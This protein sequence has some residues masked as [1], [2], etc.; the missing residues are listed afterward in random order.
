MNA[1]KKFIVLLVLSVVLVTMSLYP[2]SAQSSSGDNGKKNINLVIVLDRTRSLLQSDPNRLSQEAAKLIV[3]LMPQN[4]GKIGLVQ[5]TDKVTDRLDITAINGQEE[6]NKLKAYLDGIGVPNG[7]STDIST[8][9]KEGVGMLAGLQTL[10]HPV[11]ILLTDGKNDLNG[12]DRTFDISQRDMEQSLNTAKKKGIIVYTIGL[13]ADGSVD[14]DML[15]HIAKET[16]GKSYIVDGANLLPD[17]IDIYTNVLD[18]QLLSFGSDQISL[19]GNFDTYNFDVTNSSVADANLVIYKNGDVQARLIKPDGTEVSW[20][21]DKFIASSSRSYMSYKILNPKQGQ[22]RLMVKG[23]QNEAVKISL[24]YNYDL[25]IHMDQ[26]LSSS[27]FAGAEIPVKA[28]FMRQDTAI[29]DKNL[30][31]DMSAVAVV[32]NISAKTSEKVPLTAGEKDYHGKI[33]FEQPGNYSVYVLA[34][35]KALTSKSDPQTI[36][37][38]EKDTPV[39]AT[40]K[41][42]FPGEKFLYTLLGILTATVLVI[43]LLKGIPKFL[44]NAKPKLLFGK[45]NLKVINTKTGREEVRQSKILAPYGTSVTLSKLAENSTGLLNKIVLARNA[46]GVWLTNSEASCEDLAV[47]V[48]GDKVAPGQKVLLT[49]GSTLRVVAGEVSIKVEGRFSEF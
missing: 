34:E 41:R 17:I 13:N 45:I 11:I 33:K 36:Q 22:W 1:G 29:E 39:T 10:E 12:S 40:P 31:K 24:L 6:K 43:L 20:D 18:Y 19:N 32:E 47:S 44:G 30:Y 21:N 5:Y 38:T 49:N 2:V 16:G 9:L 8:G 46:Q 27:I 26:L 15:L 23:T 37:I 28:N 4:G 25:A 48:N 7:Q 14:K 42:L 3:D 35:G